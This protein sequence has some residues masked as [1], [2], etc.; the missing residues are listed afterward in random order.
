MI[1]WQ[2]SFMEGTNM[3][4]R[5]ILV[6]MV[7][8]ILMG[9]AAARAADAPTTQSDPQPLIESALDKYKAGNVQEAI[10]AL[11]KAIALLQASQR[12]G[13]AAFFPKAPQG[14]KAGKLESHSLSAGGNQEETQI[15]YTTMEQTYT[16]ESD[17]ARVTVTLANSPQL[18]EAYKGMMESFGNPQMLAAMN[19]DPNHHIEVVNQEEWKGWSALN[20]GQDAQI[21]AFNGSYLLT[22]QV[23][24]EDKAALELFWKAIDLKGLGAQGATKGK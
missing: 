9:Q 20:K 6:A 14:W 10:D 15:S 16:R 2:A 1:G 22:V 12:Q 13:L 19:Q 23:S 4:W 24:K 21:N 11:Q 8:V 7:G 18:I 5:T 3:G 17:G